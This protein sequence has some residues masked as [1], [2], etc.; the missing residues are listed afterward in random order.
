M[1]DIQDLARQRNTLRKS[2]IDWLAA[3]GAKGNL[4]QNC[5]AP[6]WTAYEAAEQ[7]LGAAIA[8]AG[9][10]PAVADSGS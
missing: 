5:Q 9:L 8:A 6:D 7:K 1:D 4:R 3:E 10:N 2:V